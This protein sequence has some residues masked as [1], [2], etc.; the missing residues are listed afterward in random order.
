MKL[1]KTLNEVVCNPFELITGQYAYAELDKLVNKVAISYQIF[2]LLINQQSD[3][4]YGIFVVA[5]ESAIT[6][7]IK[8]LADNLDGEL[9]NLASKFFL[10]SLF[11]NIFK[12]E[13]KML[14]KKIILNQDQANFFRDLPFILDFLG[15]MLGITEGKGSMGKLQTLV[16]ESILEDFFIENPEYGM[17]RLII[18]TGSAL[19]SLLACMCGDQ[20][21][22]WL[23]KN[24]LIILKELCE[25][26]ASFSSPSFLKVFTN[27]LSVNV[28][29]LFTKGISTMSSVVMQAQTQTSTFFK[30]PRINF[31]SVDAIV[32]V[33]MKGHH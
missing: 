17:E 3:N 2:K 11:K 6:K 15:L 33:L 1:E 8:F 32:S 31:T 21:N 4:F 7:G 20:K 10:K 9:F 28:S 23:G 30:C 22:N 24:A 18:L 16:D 26:V 27:M 25:S 13:L 29:K 5:E 19:F 14:D 12:N